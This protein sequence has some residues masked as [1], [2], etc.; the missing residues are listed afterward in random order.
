MTFKYEKCVQVVIERYY[1]V[2]LLLGRLAYVFSLCGSLW[3]F[4]VVRSVV[5]PLRF[6]LVLLLVCGLCV[7]LVPRVCLYKVVVIVVWCVVVA[8]AL[9]ICFMLSDVCAVGFVF[10]VVALFIFVLLAILP[11]FV[12]SC[13]FGVFIVFL[14]SAL[15]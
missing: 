11:V 6:R 7:V 9:L 8:F 13:F 15:P 1:I 5:P 3:V 4:I 12:F 10:L 14:F 2:I